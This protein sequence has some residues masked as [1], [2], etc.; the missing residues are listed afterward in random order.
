VARAKAAKAPAPLPAR[1]VQE[2][3][4]GTPVTKDLAVWLTVL[5]RRADAGDAAACKELVAAYDAVPR[6]WERAAVV[7]ETAEHSWLDL[8]LAPDSGQ[9]FTREAMRRDLDR[10]RRELAGPEPTPLERL[11]VDRIVVCWLNATYAEAAHAQRL[12]G[13]VSFKEAEFHQRRSE[14]AQRQLL[15]AVTTLATVRRLTRPVVQVNV[16]EQQVNVAG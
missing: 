4:P 2:L 3:G 10:L 14:R 6:L 9:L 12:R 15:R 8:L 7:Q 5:A 1:P 16:A 13:G 11:L